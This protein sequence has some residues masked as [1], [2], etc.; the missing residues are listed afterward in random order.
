[1]IPPLPHSPNQ[2][3]WA[4]SRQEDG[5]WQLTR[6]RKRGSSLSCHLGSRL[7]LNTLNQTPWCLKKQET[8]VP[9]AL[10]HSASGLPNHCKVSS[11]AKQLLTSCHPFW[12]ARV[13][14]TQSAE[15]TSP[16]NVSCCVCLNFWRWLPSAV[17]HEHL[18]QSVFSSLLPESSVNCA[19]LQ[20][21]DYTWIISLSFPCP[22]S[23]QLRTQEVLSLSLWMN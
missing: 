9:S 23:S 15:L 19:L 12:A 6:R 16:E 14:W 17:Y 22:S 11:S 1:M 8:E 7:S 3:H 4:G 21:Y 10:W 20:M 13:A 18:F 5:K 2:S